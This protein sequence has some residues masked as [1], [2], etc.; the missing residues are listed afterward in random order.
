MKQRGRLYL[1]GAL[2]LVTWVGGWLTYEHDLERSAWATYREEQTRNTEWLARQ[3][4]GTEVP[5]FMALLEDGP[6][7]GVDWCIP[8]LPGVLLADSHEEYGPLNGSGGA[9]LVLYYGFGTAVLCE[10]WG[11]MS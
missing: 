4:Q 9:K 7:A 10:L 6:A 3:P 11:W 5:V 1:L 8:V 2:Y